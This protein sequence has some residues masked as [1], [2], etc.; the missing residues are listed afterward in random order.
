MLLI[1]TLMRTQAGFHAVFTYFGRISPSL[2]LLAAGALGVLN[3]FDAPLRHALAGQLV[4]E[5]DDIPNAIALN[6]LTFN[7][8]RFIGPP[9]AGLLLV[10]SSEAIC[11]AANGLSFLGL[12]AALLR[13]DS[14]SVRPL[15]VP[16][17][18]AL[19]E[20]IGYVR[21]SVPVRHLLLQVALL[22][23]FAATY[24]PM[25]PTFA[26]DVYAGGPKTLGWLLGSA[27]AGAMAASFY[28]MSRNS[29]RGLTNV[30]ANANLLAALSLTGFALAG[31]VWLATSLLFLL[32]FAMII[33]NGSTNTILQ[34][35]LPSTMRGRVLALYTA[36][37]LGAAAV[38]GLLAGWV[39]SWAG[40]Q[41]TLL[42]AGI[43]LLVAAT[44]FGRKRKH[45]QAHLGPLYAAQGIPGATPP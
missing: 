19:R 12:I 30:V 41:A 4:A 13:I 40:P 38:G 8:A 34:T 43:L 26:G 15:P 1:Q 24:L 21:A 39:A 10:A 32:G 18:S 42:A 3:S 33:C 44:R 45:L 6:T 17:G 29:V 2:I 7:V 28:L 14:P 25:M 5:R 31:A 23:F 37:N 27:G 22:N 36:A 16:F 35:V 9:L 20:G 11:F